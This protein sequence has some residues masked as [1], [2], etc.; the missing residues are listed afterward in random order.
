MKNSVIL[1]LALT[2]AL[3][4]G[5]TSL[6][7]PTQKAMVMVER[8][9][10][11]TVVICDANDFKKIELERLVALVKAGQYQD[12]TFNDA[13]NLSVNGSATKTDVRDHSNVVSATPN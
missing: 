3:L 13:L 6:H 10:T 7:P 4:T 5:C 8:P 11:R 12:Y 1:A 9:P 2:L